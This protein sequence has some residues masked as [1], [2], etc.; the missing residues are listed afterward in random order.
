MNAGRK[1]LGR[2]G[3]FAA[4]WV[5]RGGALACVLG[6]ALGAAGAWAQ[7][8]AAAPA[9]RLALGLIVKLKDSQVNSVVRLPASVRPSDTAQAQRLR[10]AAATNRKRVGFLVQ[11]P[12]AYGAHVIHQ[13]HYTTVAEAEA[14]AA[15]LRLDPDVEW[16]VVNQMERAAAGVTFPAS[17]GGAYSSHQWMQRR[18]TLGAETGV[19]PGVANFRKAW[20]T[21]NAAPVNLSPVVVA[22]LDTGKLSHPDLD[23]RMLQGYDFVSEVGFSRDGNGLDADPTDP[24]DYLLQSEINANPNLYGSNCTA[25]SSSWHGTSVMSMLTPLADSTFMGPGA[26]SMLP[27]DKAKV[28]PVRIGGTCGALVSDIIEGMLWS[29]GV[30]YQGSPARNPNPARV[31]NL[32]FG[33]EGSCQTG[34]ERDVLYR[35]TVAT[36]R[37]KGALV[38]ASAGNGDNLSGAAGYVGPTRPASC[39]GV[40]AV[41]ALRYDGSK[42]SYANTVDGSVTRRA[43]GYYGLA[44]AGGDLITSNS[45]QSLNLLTNIGDTTANSSI[46]TGF[47]LENDVCANG[48]CTV[49]EG[50]S[51]AAPQV[52]AVAALVLSVAPSLTTDQ[53]TDL[54]LNAASAHSSVGLPL[55]TAYTSSVPNCRCT[56]TTCGKGVLDAD[57]ALAAAITYV[58][59]NPGATAFA[60]P[61]LSATYFTPERLKSSSKSGGGGGASDDLSLLALLAAVLGLTW[62]RWRSDAQARA[63]RAVRIQGDRLKGDRR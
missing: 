7:G 45:A 59:N 31:I 30:D 10:M 61:E 37:S 41:T 42:A 58:Q 48:G 62:W 22:V 21:L 28:L 29:A 3:E 13:G 5:R 60:A 19:G 9:E 57:V 54:L 1:G 8:V 33:G 32:S 38:V 12:T 6:L 50:T 17:P 35:Q 4:T 11:K 55:C 43:Q 25:H 26:L 36:L 44:V 18:D 52:A 16:V 34:D 14:E 46:A 51:F 53:L 20:D 2:P 15:K 63:L 27:A 40:I 39:P 49:T 23:A 47:K 24:G 56:D